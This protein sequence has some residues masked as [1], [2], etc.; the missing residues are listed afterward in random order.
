[1]K[2]IILRENLEKGINIVQRATSKNLTLPILGNI[3]LETDKNFLM[4]SA[5]NLEVGLRYWALAKNQ[6][7]GKITVSSKILSSL[8]SSIGEERISLKNKN[9]DVLLEGTNFKS[10]IKGEN[11]DD[12]P[13]IPKIE[14]KEYIEVN[15]FPLAKGLEQII[16]FCSPSQARP[17]ISGVYFSIDKNKVNL[18]STD[19]FRLA[20][21]TLYFEEP[22]KKGYQFILPQN[23][24][25]ELASILN[26]DNIGGNKK[27]KM[28]ISPNQILFESL[29]N[30]FKHPQLQLISRLIEGEYPDY[31][32]IIPNDFETTVTLPKKEFLNQIKLASLF[33]SKINEVELKIDS[34]KK[35]VVIESQSINIGSNKSKIKAD[36]KGKD[37]DIIFNCRFLKE[38]IDQITEPNIVLN[39][40][41][42]KKAVFIKGED[43]KDFFYVVMPINPH[44]ET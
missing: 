11:P 43:N 9:Y 7:E 24:S 26:P 33:S 6:E 34:K 5:T 12:F 28:F 37:V 40:N 13:I 42:N 4:M 32:G 18:V 30:D 35:E 41:G 20:Q 10:R 36:V 23:T 38:G 31:K 22:I 44:N 19:S 29:F 16:N 14:T 1:M 3:L 21:K 27:I 2:T 25:R 8:I 15:P 17:E 39:L